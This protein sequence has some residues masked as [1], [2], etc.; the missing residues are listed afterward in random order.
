MLH[1]F[2]KAGFSICHNLGQVSDAAEESGTVAYQFKN[3]IQIVDLGLRLADAKRLNL[4]SER[5]QFAGY[6]DPD[7]DITEEE[8][9]FLRSNRRVELNAI[10]KSEDFVAFV[11]EKLRGAGIQEKL[12]PADDVLIKAYRRAK[13]VRKLNAYIEELEEDMENNSDIFKTLR[14][15]IQKRLKADRTLSWDAV[16]YGIVSETISEES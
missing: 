9:A 2:D 4:K 15:R 5:F 6:F 7:W 14:K 10:V 3:E 1:D 11:E 8:K 12:I 13:S 16:L